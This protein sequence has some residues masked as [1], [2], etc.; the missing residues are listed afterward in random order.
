[1][2]YFWHAM[3][4][5]SQGLNKIPIGAVKLWSLKSVNLIY[6]SSIRNRHCL[7][8]LPGEMCLHK[9]PHC[10][11]ISI[12][13]S[14]ILKLWPKLKLAYLLLAWNFFFPGNRCKSKAESD[15]KNHFSA[16]FLIHTQEQVMAEGHHYNG[17]SPEL[18]NPVYILNV[19]VA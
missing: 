6:L 7:W 2:G 12:I 15:K 14:K 5:C 17:K 19:L 8:L 13:W 16:I 4:K 9:F 1:M 11:K 3:P 10:A 18:C